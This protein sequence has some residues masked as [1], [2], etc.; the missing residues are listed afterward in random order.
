MRRMVEHLTFLKL[1]S[2]TH[3]TQRRALLKTASLEQISVISEIAH[4]FLK[5]VIPFT[6]QEKTTLS[7]HKDIIRKIAK[8]TVNR[9]REFVVKHAPIIAK[10]L[11]VVLAKLD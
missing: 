2:T 7:I 3:P 1:I 5:G 11:K 6:D 9:N 8:K 10:L 4:N